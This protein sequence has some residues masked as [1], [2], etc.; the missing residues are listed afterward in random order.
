VHEDDPVGA[1]VRRET[2]LSSTRKLGVAMQQGSKMAPKGSGTRRSSRDVR[3]CR[4]ALGV[5]FDKPSLNKTAAKA[6]G[7]AVVV[8]D[9]DDEEIKVS[10]TEGR[11]KEEEKRGCGVSRRRNGVA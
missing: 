8:G 3:Q 9:G 11:R 4:R 7:I 1:D 5:D 10:E 6:T 2:L